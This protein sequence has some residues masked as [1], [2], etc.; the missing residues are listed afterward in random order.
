MAKAKPEKPKKVAE[1][2]APGARAPRVYRV[3]PKLAKEAAKLTAPQT[4]AIYEVLA[5]N[6]DGLTAEQIREKLT[7]LGFTSKN[8]PA[9]IAACLY[10]LRKG[11]ASCKTPNLVELVKPEAAPAAKP[12]A[13]RREYIKKIEKENKVVALLEESRQKNTRL[14]KAEAAPAPT[15]AA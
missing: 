9:V 3:N 8:P 11:V 5:H 10:D 15:P 1:G 13:T 2:K 4:A 6:R 14:E 12:K 7:K